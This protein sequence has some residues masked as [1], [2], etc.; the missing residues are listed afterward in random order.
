MSFFQYLP[1]ASVA[2]KNVKK[3]KDDSFVKPQPKTFVKESLPAKKF[4]KAKN[5]GV[6]RLDIMDKIDIHSC[7]ILYIDN[8]I[9]TKI[10]SKIRSLPEL[11]KDL[12]TLQ[13]VICNSS[14]N[15]DKIQAKTESDI[16]RRSIQDI[17]GGF[18][19]SLYLLKTTDLLLE[20]RKLST[21]TTDNSFVKIKKETT[22]E[23]VEKNI[24]KNQI[25]LEFIRIAKNYIDLENFQQNPKKIVCDQCHNSSFVQTT[26]ETILVCKCG[27][28]IEIIDDSPSFK[29]SE[30]VNMSSRYTYTCRGHFNE[31]MNRFEG[32]QK[33]EI[34]SSVIQILKNEMYLH[35]LTEK[36]VTKDHI[37]MFLSEKKLNE[38]YA[39][40]NLI[41]F[42]I[43]EIN[44]PDITEY[45][46]E[47]LE[48]L[49][50][51][52]EAYREVKEFD[53]MNS[54]NV[55]WKLYK[56]LQLLD[57][58]CK[59][60]DFFCLKTPTKQGEH[61][62]KWRDMVDYLSHKYPNTMTSKGKRRWRHIRTL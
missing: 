17:E 41:Y 15:V 8:L 2:A 54:L 36:T 45:R 34:D 7:D 47:L 37:Y 51:T 27:N 21:E 18:E 11:Q 53:R 26:E 32:K 35:G 30:R 12:I 3:E 59:K 20:Y 49:D 40:I 55:N 13:W 61:E 62:E 56:L 50:Q 31:A 24:R 25:V 16:L 39:D 60:D 10:R 23:N 33:T 22:T 52:E 14:E 44:P 58:P 42:L 57:F 38:Y 29:D 5:E 46:T 4:E 1:T 28:Q 6:K 19:L 9:K 48:M 43:T